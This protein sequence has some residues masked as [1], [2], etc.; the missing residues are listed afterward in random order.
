MIY[1]GDITFTTDQD[2]EVNREVRIISN[3]K[4]S[5]I[6]KGWFIDLQSPIY[7]HSNVVTN[8]EDGVTY[9]LKG[10]QVIVRA[11]YRDSNDGYTDL[12]DG[13]ILFVT[14]VPNNADKCLPSSKNYLMSLD[15]N[16]G[17][18][19]D[20]IS[21]DINDDGTIDK[22]DGITTGEE[23][24]FGTKEYAST[25]G[26]EIGS[27]QAPTFMDILDSQGNKTDEEVLIFSKASVCKT[28]GSNCSYAN[29]MKG[30]RYKASGTG[31][32]TS[33]RELRAN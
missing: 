11:V 8:I 15:A 28:G 20:Y 25:S 2:E 17:A 9:E 21:V 7:T 18:R 14:D 29:T 26:F 1:D 5:G 4:Y 32:R 16:M 23:D 27:R 24:S 19:F 12:G 10:E 13:R 31:K 6:Q 22:G 30:K 3:N 33:W